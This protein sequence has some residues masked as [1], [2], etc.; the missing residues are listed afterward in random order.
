M[1]QGHARD[2]QPQDADRVQRQA[3][4]LEAVGLPL[5]SLQRLQC[6]IEF[7][8]V[9]TMSA[10]SSSADSK[11]SPAKPS[12]E[13]SQHIWLAGLGAMA[14]AQSQGTKA[15][16][17]LIADG[18]AFQRKTQLA[19]Q[20]KISEATEQLS[21]LAKDFGQQTTVRVDRLEHLFEDR[22]ARALTRLGIPSMADLQAL[23]ERVAQLEAQLDR[24]PAKV[25]KSGKSAPTAALTAAPTA[26]KAPTAPRA[27]KALAKRRSTSRPSR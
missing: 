14:K 9:L 23:T 2:G 26:A 19:A 16:E 4:I 13:S 25:T 3:L 11:N 7:P 10:K 24:P 15:F 17:A 5:R 1:K 12:E 27:A 22:V 6:E 21:H 18:L 20:E 8:G